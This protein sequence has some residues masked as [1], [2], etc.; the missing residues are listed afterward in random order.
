MAIVLPSRLALQSARLTQPLSQL[1]GTIL[2]RRDLREID[3]SPTRISM[4]IDKGHTDT[5]NV[6][7][8]M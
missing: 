6:I 8:E 4:L 7:A 2:I 5:A 1:V 3:F